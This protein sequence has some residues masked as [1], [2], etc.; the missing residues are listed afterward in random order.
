MEAEITD[1]KRKHEV[2]AANWLEFWPASDF[3]LGADPEL[4]LLD[5]LEEHSDPHM[6]TAQM[7]LMPPRLSGASGMPHVEH[8]QV[9]R[10]IAGGPVSGCRQPHSGSSPPSPDT[11]PSR[12]PLSQS[13]QHDDTGNPL[14]SVSGQLCLAAAMTPP[15]T[16]VTLAFIAA[17]SAE[18]QPG[19]IFGATISAAAG[20]ARAPSPSP[21]V[22]ATPAWAAAAA[23]A[24]PPAAC[25]QQPQLGGHAPNAARGRGRAV[26]PTTPC[27]QYGRRA[28]AAPYVWPAVDVPLHGVTPEHVR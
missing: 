1:G 23:P 28:P 26:A 7:P 17:G 9:R 19:A 5:G 11:P 3:P 22:P 20:A 10:A 2:D 4:G 27:R 25:F 13:W 18:P 12:F 8:H 16:P 6:S 21:A 14:G 24:A 15:N